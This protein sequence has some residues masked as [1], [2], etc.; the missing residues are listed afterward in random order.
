MSIFDPEVGQVF[1]CMNRRFVAQIYEVCDDQLCV[2]LGDIWFS[3]K[4]NNEYKVFCGVAEY[5]RFA[6]C[7][8]FAKGGT[9]QFCYPYL[10]H[11]FINVDLINKKR[12]L[13]CDLSYSEK[14]KIV[15]YDKALNI[16]ESL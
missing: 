5:N 9:T 4:G 11:W 14:F 6:T 15:S 13:S 12:D 8:K 3:E 7:V 16:I 2:A 10:E 1:T